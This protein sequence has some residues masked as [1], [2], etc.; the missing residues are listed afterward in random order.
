MNLY[1]ADKT[2][3]KSI[4]QNTYYFNIYSYNQIKLIF[5]KH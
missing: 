2:I 4:M 3:S 1:A 5:I